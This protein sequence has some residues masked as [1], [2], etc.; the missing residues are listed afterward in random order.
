M[1]SKYTDDDSGRA[2][3]RRM[4]QKESISGKKKDD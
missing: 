1:S 2:L 4:V 3:G